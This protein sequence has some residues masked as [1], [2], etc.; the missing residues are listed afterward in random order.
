MKTTFN[1]IHSYK[2]AVLVILLALG[3]VAANTNADGA[4]G[5]AARLLELS[6]KPKAPMAVP[7]GTA[8]ACAD[9]KDESTVK[10]DRTARGAYKPEVAVT[11]HLCATCKTTISFEGH[12]KAKSATATHKCSKGTCVAKKN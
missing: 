5:G 2:A 6:G 9:C 4:K 1:P 3:A 11:K 10:T 7:A 12:G 8:M